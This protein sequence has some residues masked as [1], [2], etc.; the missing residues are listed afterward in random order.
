MGRGSTPTIF[1]PIEFQRQHHSSE[2][3]HDA[4]RSAAQRSTA[5]QST[6]QHSTAQHS[7]AQHSTA[8][9]STAQH[10]TALHNTAQHNTAQH[11]AAQHSTAQ[12][13]TA[14]HSTAQHNTAQHSTAQHSTALHN[15]TQHNTAQH[16]AAQHSTA[17]H[18]SYH[19]PG[20]LLQLE[21]KDIHLKESLQRPKRTDGSTMTDELVCAREVVVFGAGVG[22]LCLVAPA[23][24]ATISTCG[25]M[26]RSR[27]L[28]NSWISR[29]RTWGS[30]GGGYWREWGRGCRC[31]GQA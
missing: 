5:Q 9:H 20:R 17:Q 15:T 1:P 13:S 7:T 24:P 4:Q 18:S 30:G 21:T 11:R 6:P 10:S 23:T 2:N 27:A 28:F 26:R 25:A 22:S 16:R 8:Q 31:G 14:Q 29:G 3:E 19:L 12:H